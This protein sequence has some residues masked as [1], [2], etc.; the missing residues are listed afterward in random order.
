MVH[1]YLPPEAEVSLVIHQLHLLDPLLPRY[2]FHL[3]DHQCHTPPLV[4]SCRMN[5]R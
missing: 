5:K 4:W 1:S 3:R 2:Q